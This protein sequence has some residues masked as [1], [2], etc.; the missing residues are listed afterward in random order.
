MCGELGEPRGAV[1]GNDSKPASIALN[2]GR[3]S[4]AQDLVQDPVDVGAQAGCA[5]AWL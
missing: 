5:Q 1:D 2:L 3:L 4:R